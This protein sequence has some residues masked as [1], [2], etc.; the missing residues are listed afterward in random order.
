VKKLY[1]LGSGLLFAPIIAVFVHYRWETIQQRLLGF[2]SPEDSYQV[3]HS[4][5][6]L[7]SGGLWGLGLGASEQKLQFLP[8]SHT[9]FILAIIGEELG[10]VGCAA[11]IVLFAALLWSGVA[12][13]W[14]SR[15]LHSFLIGSG[16]VVSLVFQAVFNMAVVTASAP[17]KGIPLPLITFGGSGLF[18]TM[19]QVGVLLALDRANR[20]RPVAAASAAPRSLE[21]AEVSA[22]VPA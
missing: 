7:G 19:L 12:I 4:L 3:K 22:E 15:D 8:E 11:V 1:L 6:A 18:V 17:T 10:L 2:L 20:R 5:T 13:V 21:G 14:P 16:I 9:D